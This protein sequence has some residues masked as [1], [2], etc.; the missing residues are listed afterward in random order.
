MACLAPMRRGRAR[1]QDPQRPRDWR[2]LGDIVVLCVHAAL[3]RDA[4]GG[5]CAVRV[6]LPVALPCAPTPS[7]VFADSAGRPVDAFDVAVARALASAATGAAEATV[8]P[9]PPPLAA[10]MV[11]AGAVAPATGDEYLDGAG[12][13]GVLGWIRPSSPCCSGALRNF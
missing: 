2:A 6:A 8:T 11:L 12:V 10:A 7:A 3:L 9:G 4:P 13:L 5:A 1:P